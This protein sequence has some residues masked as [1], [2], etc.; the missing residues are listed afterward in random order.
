MRHSPP[1]PYTKV[2]ISVR[3][4]VFLCSNVYGNLPFHDIVFKTSKGT[5]VYTFKPLICATNIALAKRTR[6]KGIRKGI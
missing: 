3:I 6:M 1:F 2:G 4:R 5:T